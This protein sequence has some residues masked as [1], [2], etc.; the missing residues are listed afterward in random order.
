MED[1][2]VGAVFRAVRHRRGWRQA[3][4]ASRAGAS[5]S[6]VSLVERGHL[7][8]V[9]LATLRQVGAALD[10]RIDVVPRW[11]GADLDR[12]LTE[13]HAALHESVT[14]FFKG[15]PGWQLV[16]EVSFSIFGE[17]GIIDGLAW[18]ATTRTVLVIELKTEIVDIQD[19]MGTM[20]R[21]RRLA[22]Q[23]AAEHGWNAAAVAC[24]VIVADSRTN[25][26]RIETYATV[27]RA[28]FPADGRQIRRWLRRPV[29]TIAA[30]SMWP[31]S[32]GS[33]TRPTDITRKRVRVGGTTRS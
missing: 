22:P 26:R 18:H 11:R 5:R 9:P 13:G 15:L 17:R 33:S 32:S 7:D 30:L 29:G 1:L 28:A 10:V 19:L 31:S 6:L 27:L 8:R 14:G 3:D 20:D 21:R 4:V 23:I 12:M 2:R 16:P 24:W 25:R